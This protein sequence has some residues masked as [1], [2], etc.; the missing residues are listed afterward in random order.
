MRQ[1]ESSTHLLLCEVSNDERREET[2]HRCKEIR[3]SEDMSRKIGSQ[4]LRV[5]TTRHHSS[6]IESQRQCYEHNA[7]EGILLDEA[8]PEQN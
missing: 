3:Y 6:S 2:A 1:T 4:V 7:S 5:L 8:E